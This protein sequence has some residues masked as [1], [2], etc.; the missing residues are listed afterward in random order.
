MALTTMFPITPPPLKNHGH[1]I[2]SLSR[3]VKWLGGLVEAEGI[4]VFTGFPATGILYDGDRVVGVRTGDRGIGRHGE[5]KANFEPGVDIRAKVTILTTASAGMSRR[6]S[7]APGVDAGF[8]AALCHRSCGGPEDRLPR[9][10]DPHHGIPACMEE[11]EVF[12]L[13]IARRR[14]ASGSSAA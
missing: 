9:H 4:D 12:Y 3:F 10:G 5:K 2:I 11:F 13:C 1:Y 14:R 6:L 7:V 8:T